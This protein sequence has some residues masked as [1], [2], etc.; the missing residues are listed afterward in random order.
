MS[1][2]AIGV[3]QL[4]DDIRQA[5]VKLIQSKAKEK[6]ITDLNNLKKKKQRE[7]EERE[8]MEDTAATAK[9]KKKKEEDVFRK[10]KTEKKKKR[11]NEDE[12][13]ELSSESEGGGERADDRNE[14]SE[15][16]YVSSSSEEDES[17]DDIT[18][19]IGI[20]DLHFDSTSCRET[21]RVVVSTSGTASNVQI[22]ATV[23]PRSVVNVFQISD[24]HSLQ[25]IDAGTQVY[26]DVTFDPSQY[27]E[28]ETS[29][30]IQGILS[31]NTMDSGIE[32][33]TTS[34]HLFSS[35]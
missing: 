5:E 15:E 19:L 24:K 12:D 27:K 35:Y 21:K 7:E 32:L 28:S 23:T 11:E 30:D 9:G 20:P 25:T 16:D 3:R 4:N 26:I 34:K 8:G 2:D 33:A 29:I 14:S 10:D 18:A 17:N 31:I 22:F 13:E 6:M 1:N